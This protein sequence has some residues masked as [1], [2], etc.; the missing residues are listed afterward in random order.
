MRGIKKMTAIAMLAVMMS[1]TAQTAFATQGVILSDRDGV[2]LG[3]KQKDVRTTDWVGI[4]LD[5]IKT[6]VLLSDRSGVILSD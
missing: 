1:L 2:I 3:D 6:G 5:Y 4:I